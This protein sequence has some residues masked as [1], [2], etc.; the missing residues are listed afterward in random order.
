VDFD[1]PAS[2]PPGVFPRQGTFRTGGLTPSVSF[3]SRDNFFT[4]T[5]GVFA[6]ASCSAFSEVLGSE[7]E[8][9]K[10]AVVAIGYVPLHPRLTLG[11]RGDAAASFGDAPFYLRPFVMMRGVAAMRYQGEEI[12]QVEGELR[13]QFWQRWSV[14]GFGGIG[15]AWN[16]LDRFHDRQTVTTWGT[17]LRYEL[18]RKYGLHMGVDVA[19]GPDTT[20][21]YVQLGSAWMRP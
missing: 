21:F 5:R 3:D 13:W 10:A 6:E 17:G 16:D 7:S 8:F 19:F 12:A 18:A 1:Q 9:Q 15:A 11:V 20:A 14:V 2:L 4:P